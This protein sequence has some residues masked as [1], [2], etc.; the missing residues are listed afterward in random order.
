MQPTVLPDPVPGPCGRSSEELLEGYDPYQ[1][2]RELAKLWIVPNS[3]PDAVRSAI[4]S[5][6]KR[7]LRHQHEHTRGVLDCLIDHATGGQP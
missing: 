4:M 6:L 7:Y 1:H 2:G 3:S 5:A